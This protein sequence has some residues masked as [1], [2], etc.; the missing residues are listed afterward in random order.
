MGRQITFENATGEAAAQGPV[1]EAAVEHAAD[2]T[3]VPSIPGVAGDKAEIL[4]R[5]MERRAKE[6]GK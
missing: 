5:M 3:G 1:V 2:T 4:R 6:G